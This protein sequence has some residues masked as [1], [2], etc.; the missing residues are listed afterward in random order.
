MRRVRPVRADAADAGRDRGRTYIVPATSGN[1]GCTA[2]SVHTADSRRTDRPHI[3]RPCP[4][5]GRRSTARRGP[6]RS[7]RGL[8]WTGRGSRSR[9]SNRRTRG[10]PR[11]RH[12]CRRARIGT[13]SGTSAIHGCTARYRRMASGRG[14]IGTRSGTSGSR[15]CRGRCRRT[16]R[17]ARIGTRPETS[18]SRGCRA[19]CRRTASPVRRPAGCRRHRAACRY[20]S[21]R[22]S[23]PGCGDTRSDRTARRPAGTRCRQDC[24]QATPGLH[25]GH[26]VT[27]PLC[28]AASDI[29]LPGTSPLPS[30][31][32]PQP[33]SCE[34]TMR[35]PTSSQTRPFMIPSATVV[36]LLSASKGCKKNRGR[37]P[38]RGGLPAA[39]AL[40]EREDEPGASGHGARGTRCS[41]PPD[42]GGAHDRPKRSRRLRMSSPSNSSRKRRY[43][44]RDRARLGRVDARAHLAADV[45]AVGASRRGSASRRAATPPAACRCRRTAP[46]SRCPGCSDADQVSMFS[47]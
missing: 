28:A 7:D 23:T 5:T 10:S 2:A 46:T 30:P 43:A 31:L 32:D 18:E 40:F 44:L 41:R 27:Q 12:S 22:C 35:A 24:G 4:Y 39:S 37:E 16:A 33:I 3:G 25:V 47:T 15:G 45:A 26:T 19:P 9:C 20:R 6:H 11:R 29:R 14:R 38:T 1:R 42:C 21:S 13:A 36:S 34:L 8:H 17:P